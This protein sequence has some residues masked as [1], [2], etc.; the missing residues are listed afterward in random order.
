MLA[1]SEKRQQKDHILTKAFILK[2]YLLLLQSLFLFGSHVWSDEP[3][4]KNNSIENSIGMKLVLIPAGEFMMGSDETP[5]QLAVA[6][7]QYDGSRFTSLGDEAPVHKVRITRS[8][9]LGQH[10]VTVR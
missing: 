10:E 1:I 9:Y 7:P 8:F 4:K 5:Q 2:T 6:Y 3:T